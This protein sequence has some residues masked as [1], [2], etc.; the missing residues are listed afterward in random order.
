LNVKDANDPG[1]D[2]PIII[3]DSRS[4][5][6]VRN[7]QDRRGHLEH[8]QSRLRRPVSRPA[9]SRKRRHAWKCSVGIMSLN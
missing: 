3:N 9:R 8:R 4:R 7:R 5:V 2:Q 1:P 6:V